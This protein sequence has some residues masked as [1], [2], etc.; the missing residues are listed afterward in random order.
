MSEDFI[1]WFESEYERQEEVYERFPSEKPSKKKFKYM[2]LSN[3]IFDV[4]TYDENLDYEFGKKIYEVIKVIQE[5]KNFDYISNSKKYETYILVCNLLNQFELIE[6]G[7]SV[8]GAWFDK[9]SFCKNGVGCWKFDNTPVYENP[10]INI[11][12]LIK[13]LEV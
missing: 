13:W 3:Y 10:I 12:E 11:K 7:T 5:R 9:E 2:F 4:I 6:W 1:K 8:R